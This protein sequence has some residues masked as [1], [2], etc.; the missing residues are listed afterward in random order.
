MKNSKI[1]TTH[2]NEQN[3]WRT[4]N[5]KNK[6]NKHVRPGFYYNNNL[7]VVSAGFLP[8]RVINNN[9]NISLEFLM[10]RNW[11]YLEDFGGKSSYCDKSILDIVCRETFEESN[12]IFRKR[13]ILNIIKDVEPIYLLNAKY[14]LYVAKINKYYDPESFGDMEIYNGSYRTVEWVS[15]EQLLTQKYNGAELHPRLEVNIFKTHLQQ[16]KNIYYPKK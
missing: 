6:S 15:L 10:Q 8:Y 14:L 1:S 13:Y 12:G 3:S 16:M 7:C 5:D 2:K 4:R 11:G 9:G